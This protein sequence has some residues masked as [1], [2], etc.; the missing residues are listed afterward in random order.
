[1]KETLTK[2]TFDELRKKMFFTINCNFLRLSFNISY[3]PIKN[4]S[5]K[6]NPFQFY[7]FCDFFYNCD[8]FTIFNKKT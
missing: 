6:R 1:M 4:S 7:H 8:Q 3:W 2:D 5:K